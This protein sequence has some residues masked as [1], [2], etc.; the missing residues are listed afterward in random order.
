MRRLTCNSPDL[1]SEQAHG[2]PSFFVRLPPEL[3][4]L[5]LDHLPNSS[6][7][8]LALCSRNLLVTVGLPSISPESEGALRGQWTA[9]LLLLERDLP[10]HIFCKHCRKLHRTQHLA[11]QKRSPWYQGP[12]YGVWAPKCSQVDHYRRAFLYFYPRFSFDRVQMALKQARLG[13]DWRQYIDDIAYSEA[14]LEDEIFMDYRHGRNNWFH[15]KHHIVNNELYIRAQQWTLVRAKVKRPIWSIQFGIVCGHL[16]ASKDYADSNPL[17]KALMCKV[18][19]ILERDLPCFSCVI[20]LISCRH[21]P[22][23]ASINV[24]LLSDDRLAL[25]VTKWMR[26]GSGVSRDDPSWASRLVRKEPHEL[27]LERA[28]LADLPSAQ[29]RAIRIRIPK[30]GYG[31]DSFRYDEEGSIRAICGADDVDAR[32]RLSLTPEHR[33]Q[34]LEMVLPDPSG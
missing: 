15:F 7:S 33:R 1:T 9:L 14:Q 28:Y 5:I 34:L 30:N 32:S 4:Q 26:I 18:S 21:C 3:V 10:D 12:R 27:D 11:E 6:L 17:R 22:T 23:E 2:L 24:K 25:V 19:H 31:N 20:D 16:G 29:A 13:L 8:S